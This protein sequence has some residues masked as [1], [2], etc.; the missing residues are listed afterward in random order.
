MACVV[1]ADMVGSTTLMAALAED[2]FDDLR[3]THFASLRK[4][5]GTYGGT[6]IK[7]TGDG[8][9]ATFGSVVDAV[10]CAVAMRQVTARQ[11]QT[12]SAALAIRIGLCLSEVTFEKGDVYGVPVVEAARLVAAAKGGQILATALVRAVAGI[13]SEADFATSGV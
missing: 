8:I 5:L 1:F 10:A 12:G 7:G 6:E 3:E 9:M 11:A 2:A 4:A 13:R